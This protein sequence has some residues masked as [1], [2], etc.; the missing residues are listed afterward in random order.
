MD[1][2]NFEWEDVLLISK[3]PEF[4]Y[5]AAFCYDEKTQTGYLYGGFY[6][7]KIESNSVGNELDRFKI[8]DKSSAHH[9]ENI[10]ML[11]NEK[12]SI[13]N[14]NKIVEDLTEEIMDLTEKGF[15]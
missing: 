13:Q 11:G 7:N 6:F 3:K 15:S 4:R 2:I 10:E 9:L 14:L 1:L 8:S 12:L 5:G